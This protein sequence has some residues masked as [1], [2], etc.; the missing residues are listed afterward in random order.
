MKILTRGK[1]TAAIIVAAACC[2]GG[3]SATK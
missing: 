3:P 1:D 2:K